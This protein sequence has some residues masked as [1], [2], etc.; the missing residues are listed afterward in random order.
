MQQFFPAN[1]KLACQPAASSERTISLV[2]SAHPALRLPIGVCV[3]G[4]AYSAGFVGR[5]TARANPR[6]L[7]APG[8]LSLAAELGL[9]S[10][11]LPFGY[12]H[13]DEDAAALQ[14]YCA[15][16]RDFE[17]R[18]TSAGLPVEVDPFIRHLELAHSV[19][20]KT[21]R[22]VLSSV[23]CGDRRPIGG[24]AGWQ[25]HL[26]EMIRR[27]QAIA[28]T[29]ESLGIRIGVENH[30]DA[31]SQDLLYLCESVN[32]PSVGVTLDTGN[33]LAVGEDPVA[34]A[35]A[36]LPHLVHVHLKD[37]RMMVTP[38]GYRLFHCAIGA[39]VVD[40]PALFA[41]FRT[42]PGVAWHIEM[43]ALGERHIRILTDDYWAGHAPRTV[44][45]LLPVL[46]MRERAE[47]DVEWR[48][49][50]EAGQEQ[51]LAHWEME[52]LV[53]SVANMQATLNGEAV[54]Y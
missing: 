53:E 19:G 11:E 24:L 21:V 33:P 41:L 10:V 23:L 40:F 9:S 36:I 44:E 15:Q 50:W 38:E 3:Y 12:I 39:G 32:S 54:V 30:Q 22:C 48:T 2:T 16:A 43:A 6:P 34:F 26:D 52:R 18:V 51:I 27:F 35:R 1:R 29:A 5:G 37:Y 42:R 8:L 4:L 14:A 25:R 45:Q 13:P 47:G 46:R 28:P 31:T 17:L 49:P 20:I 7:D